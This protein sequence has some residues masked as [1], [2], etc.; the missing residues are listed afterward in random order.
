VRGRGHWADRGKSKTRTLENHKGFGT[1]EC[2]DALRV[3]HPANV[4]EGVENITS[5]AMRRQ[6][7]LG[8]V[9]IVHH[10]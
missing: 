3:L 5:G 7:A 8:M 9:R 6:A 10:L 4:R 1:Q 2:V